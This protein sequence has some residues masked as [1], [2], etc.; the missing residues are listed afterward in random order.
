VL[1][2]QGAMGHSRG[3]GPIR[4]AYDDAE[5]ITIRGT[6]GQFLVSQRDPFRMS[7]DIIK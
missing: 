7:R 4:S 2:A 6:G 5:R 3:F 1:A